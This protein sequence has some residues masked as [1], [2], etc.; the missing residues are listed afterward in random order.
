MTSVDIYVRTSSTRADSDAIVRQTDDCAAFADEHGWVVAKVHAD[1][2]RSAF[3][4]TSTRPALAQA[5]HRLCTTE[6]SVLIAWRVD[7][8]TRK[9]SAEFDLILDAVEAAERR[10]VCVMDGFDSALPD[11]R[12]YGRGLAQAAWIES[13]GISQRVKSSHARRRAAGGWVAGSLPFGMTY[14]AALGHVVPDVFDGPR[15]RAAVEKILAGASLVQTARWMNEQGWPGPRGRLWQ[16]TTLSGLIRNPVIAGLSPVAV[17]TEEGRYTG[18]TIPAVDPFTG[19]PIRLGQGVV[20]SDERSRLLAIVAGRRT[21]SM[22][23]PSPM[24]LGGLIWCLSCGASTH[25]R[26]RAYTCSSVANGA[27]CAAPARGYELAV[28]AAVL[29]AL[30]ADGLVAPDGEPTATWLRRHV[31]RVDL[32]PAEGRGKRFDARRLKITLL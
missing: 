16:I 7:R 13:Q 15:L 30:E 19:E 21:A 28:D 12:S 31:Q 4:A 25:R 5:L 24:L 29:R 9:G 1:D 20:T 2:G 23:M 18:R 11:A 27:P 22:G 14:D 8:L 6:T 32:A 10:L 3:T 17:K 26:G